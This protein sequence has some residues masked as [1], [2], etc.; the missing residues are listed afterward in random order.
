MATAAQLIAQ[1]LK[2]AG[3]T[4]VYGIP[5][6]EVLVLMDA[7]REVGIE[8]IL[9]KHENNAGFMAEGAWQT[10]GRPPVL[11]TWLPA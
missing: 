4:H 2:E 3:C 5:G 7:L 10:T 11:L 8:F 6:G 1:R 9:T